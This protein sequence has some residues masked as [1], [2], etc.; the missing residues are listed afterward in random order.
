MGSKNLKAIAIRGHHRPAIAEADKFKK[1]RQAFNKAMRDSEVLY[2]DFAKD[3]TP[4][5]IDEMTEMGIYSTKN[6]S[7]TGE[8]NLVK[9]QGRDAQHEMIVTSSHCADCRPLCRLPQ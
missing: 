2:P 9:E 4:M 5:I 7:A 8:V 3:G 1:A 6:W